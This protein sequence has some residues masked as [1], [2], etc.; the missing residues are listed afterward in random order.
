MKLICS[1]HSG[2]VVL[3]STE[4]S[5]CEG[6]GVKAT[7][8]QLV[9]RARDAPGTLWEWH[10]LL[11]RLQTVPA[12]GGGRVPPQQ[13]LSVLHHQGLSQDPGHALHSKDNAGS[14]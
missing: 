1:F 9:A 14:K 11:S 12:S 2:S 6:E 8:S 13:L 5:P 10:I 7:Q 4:V 3:V